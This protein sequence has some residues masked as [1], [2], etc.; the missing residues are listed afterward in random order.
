MTRSSHINQADS[1]KPLVPSSTTALL[2]VTRATGFSEKLEALKS[3]LLDGSVDTKDF[4]VWGERYACA[5]LQRRGWQLLTRNWHSRYGEIDLV[6]LDNARQIVIVEVK[7]RRSSR[8]GTPEEAITP[9]KQR[10][11]RHAALQWLQ[12]Q[13]ALPRHHGMRFDVV[14]ILARQGSVQLHH[15]PGAF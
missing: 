1:G 9:H 8:F 14:G 6:M 15:L 12:D 10:S 11:V 7:S 13:H 2:P 4:G 5:W 3:E